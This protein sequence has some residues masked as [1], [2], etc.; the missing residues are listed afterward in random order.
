MD[1]IASTPVDT[2]RSAA[3][4][5]HL[6]RLSR[7]RS[8]AALT[9]LGLRPRH[10]VAL[11]LLREQD[12]GTQQALAAQLRIDRTNLVGLLNELETDGLIARRRSVEDRRRH[13]VDLTA[14]GAE[15]LHAAECAL[16]TAEDD[17]LHALDAD[18]RELLYQLLQQAIG[19]HAGACA[20]AAAAH[21][22]EDPDAAC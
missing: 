22:V 19:S 17:V 20:A 3:L 6:A 13:I 11:T 9:P 18:Q 7:L 12:G 5:D 16:A 8:E 14:A 4:L 21:E 10:L 15:R 1:P 2:H